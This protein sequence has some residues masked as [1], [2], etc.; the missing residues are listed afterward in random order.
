MALRQNGH[1]HPFPMNS[2]S[3]LRSMAMANIAAMNPSSMSASAL[4]KLENTGGASSSSQPSDTE[5][6]E[7]LRSVMNF[8]GNGGSNDALSALQGHSQ[9]SSRSS[10]ASGLASASSSAAANALGLL[11]RSIPHGDGGSASQSEQQQ[12]PP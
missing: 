12:W 8:G 4:G 10:S 11:A 1:H 5:R 2:S 7:T 3:H 9:H 6:M